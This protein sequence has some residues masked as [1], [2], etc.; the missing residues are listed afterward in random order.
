MIIVG[1]Y[2]L[3]YYSHV[4]ISPLS[5]IHIYHHTHSDWLSLWSQIILEL[6]CGVGG[7]VLLHKWV[8]LFYTI[9][10]CILHHVNYSILKINN[11]HTVHHE[12]V[13]TNIGPDICD[14]LFKTKHQTTSSIEDITHYIPSIFISFGIVAWIQQLW[15]TSHSSWMIYSGYILALGIV[16]MYTTT[17]FYL[18]RQ[19]D[20]LTKKFN[21][22]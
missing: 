11:I 18:W 15:Q 14:I 20:P 13:L 3:H 7:I 2:F 6:F 9:F 16:V 4:F 1:S 19:Y 17:S 22:I 8:V 10:Y 21:A 12:D 5:A